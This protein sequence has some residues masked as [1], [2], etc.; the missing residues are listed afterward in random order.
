LADTSDNARYNQF[1]TDIR[2]LLE[3]LSVDV[4][5][6]TNK[7]LS[8]LGERLTDLYRHRLVKINHSVMELICSKNLLL[9]GYDVK[10]EYPLDSS[11]IC[12]LYAVKGEGVLIVEVETGYTPPN[13]AL[14]PYTYNKARIS[15]KI[16][17]YSVY[18]NKFGLATP[19]YNVL[20]IPA[21]F[22]RP[23]RYRSDEEVSSIKQLCDLYYS[24]PPITAKQIR[25]ANLQSITLI[26]IDNAKTREIDP[27]S[28][29][30]LLLHIEAI[31]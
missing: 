8:T 13:H 30:K 28:Y 19:N 5:P 15:S 27:E 9:K 11:L 12:D 7:S 1:D 20:Q 10:L 6:S 24:S 23:P 25:E 4:D 31:V 21:L 14:D 29:L 22:S 2:S 26:N 16:A 3:K 17:R 18:S